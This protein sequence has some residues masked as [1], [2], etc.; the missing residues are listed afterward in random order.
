MSSIFFT[1]MILA[2][3]AT[4]A[5]LVMGLL[6]FTKGGAFNEKHGNKLMRLRLYCQAAALI[7]F[8]LAI[9][10]QVGG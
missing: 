1:L 10:T 8:A 6:S 7:L 3:I 5:T 2:M 9:F 4:L